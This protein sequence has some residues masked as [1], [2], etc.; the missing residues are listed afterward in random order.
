MLLPVLRST[1]PRIGPAVSATITRRQSNTTAA[2]NAAMPL[3]T[4]ASVL[5]VSA[6]N[7][8]FISPVS[9]STRLVKSVGPWRFTVA[10]GRWIA[11]WNTSRRINAAVRAAMPMETIWCMKLAA[12]PTI[13]IR[14]S[15]TISSTTPA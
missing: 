4:C 9:R 10:S 8:L 7:P 11:C 1:T 13:V 14:A 6:S 3:V 5:L 2:M 15:A 12:A